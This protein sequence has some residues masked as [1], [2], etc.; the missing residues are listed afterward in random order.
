[1]HSRALRRGFD[2][3]ALVVPVIL[4]FLVLR[5]R[6][7]PEASLGRATAFSLPASDGGAVVFQAS[8]GR[9]TILEFGASWCEPCRRTAPLLARFAKAH[10]DVALLSVDEGEARPAVLAFARAQG[11]PRLALDADGAIGARYEAR[12]LPTTVVVDPQGRIRARYGGDVPGLVQALERLR[13]HQA[14]R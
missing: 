13:L 10:S 5:T 11:V 2:A 9:L 8:P 12:G 1:M 3:L 4:L 14:E 7:M 6:E